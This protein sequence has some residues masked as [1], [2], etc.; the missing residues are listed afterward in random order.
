MR[1]EILNIK[2]ALAALM[3]FSFFSLQLVNAQE[4]IGGPYEADSATMLLM[5]FDGNL[6][7]MSD[8]SDKGTS[9]GNVSFSQSPKD[10][11]GQS[12][13]IENDAPSDSS[14]ITVPHTEHLSLTGNWTIEGWINIFTFGTGS[15]SYKWVPR[16]LNKPGEEVFYT[17][18]YYMEM[19]GSSRYFKAGYHTTA[20]GSG[21]WIEVNS[22]T[23][24]M[25][26][27][28]WYH[29][30]YIRDHDNN[31]LISVIHE[32]QGDGS[33]E[34]VF[35]GVN[36]YDPISESPPLTNT[37]DLHI[38]FAG[39]G[40]DSFL[41]G[42]VDEVRISNVVRNFEIPPVFTS[43][44]ELDNQETGSDY[45]VNV[46]AYKLGQNQQVDEVK[47]HYSVDDGD[48]Q[49]VV[50]ADEGNR[51]YSGSIPQQSIGSMVDYYYSATGTDGLTAYFPNTAVEDSSYISFGVID[52]QSQTLS[53]SFEE[54]SGAPADSSQYGN[55]VELAGNATYSEGT[56]AESYGLDLDV[57]S[58]CIVSDSPYYSSGAMQV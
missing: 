56:V 51:V 27:G 24:L 36:P 30:A 7:N 17:G 10:T 22:P 33:M 38:G 31:V 39:G 57:D 50:L 58:S 13:R 49:E 35:F 40:D 9:F 18:N 6:E 15:D 48:W 3:V 19:W 28:K 1:I 53:L 26:V 44:T 8:S 29:W 34:R 41:D 23:N 2:T 14:F 12:A 47:V 45:P 37:S 52:S 21:D 42:W 5:H 16:L 54:G 55:A 20:S 11:L 25:E 4:Q 32:L 46:E 43:V